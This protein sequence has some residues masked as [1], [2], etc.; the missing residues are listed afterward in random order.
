MRELIEWVENHKG[1]DSQLIKNNK[2]ALRTIKHRLTI[3]RQGK[4]LYD[5]GLGKR[6][7]PMTAVRRKLE[8]M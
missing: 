7:L 6:E 2:E 5:F 1:P 3:E 8:E 4:E